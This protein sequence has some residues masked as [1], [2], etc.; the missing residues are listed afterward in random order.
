[1]AFIFT[2]GTHSTQA[3]SYTTT[4]PSAN[5][6]SPDFRSALA[7]Y[8]NITVQ[9]QNCGNFTGKVVKNWEWFTFCFV[10]LIPFSLKPWNAVHCNVCNFQQ[11]IKYRPD[12]EQQM[13]SGG[14]GAIGGGGGGGGQGIPMQN[15]QQIGNQGW[16]RPAPP[17]G[18]VPQ[19]K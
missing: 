11:D 8:E 9:C 17:P 19:Y 16:N 10:P 13:Q 1:M 12:V 7:G 18:G 3:R 15:Q 5:R 2:C 6:H 14:V 4:R